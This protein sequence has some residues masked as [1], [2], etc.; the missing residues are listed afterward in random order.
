MT[1]NS[2]NTSMAYKAPVI[3]PIWLK[4]Y[5]TQDE[6]IG[7]IYELKDSTATASVI[8]AMVPAKDL[9]PYELMSNSGANAFWDDPEE[10]IYSFE[11]GE[12][13]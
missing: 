11:D 2:I 4:A 1:T 9:S 7:E 6:N 12:A 8:Y 5:K 10:D 3:Y 13:I